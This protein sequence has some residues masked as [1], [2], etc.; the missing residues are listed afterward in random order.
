MPLRPSDSSSTSPSCSS[1]MLDGSPSS[2][3]WVSKGHCRSVHHLPLTCL[4]KLLAATFSGLGPWHSTYVVSGAP[5]LPSTMQSFIISHSRF[6]T[7]Y[8]SLFTAS[9]I[10]CKFPNPRN[11]VTTCLGLSRI[12]A[13][14]PVILGYL[15]IVPPFTDPRVPV[16]MISYMVTLPTKPLLICLILQTQVWLLLTLHTTFQA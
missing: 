6:E 13:L 14:G 15:L 5:L 8:G 12:V 10:I 1:A 7:R 3:S 2:A 9:W 11:R 16:W 4:H